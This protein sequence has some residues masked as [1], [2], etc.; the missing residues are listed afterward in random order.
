MATYGER[1]LPEELRAH[2]LEQE[3][4]TDDTLAALVARSLDAAPSQSINVWS[5][6]AEW[7]GT[8][9]EIAEESRRLA[10]ALRAAGIDSGA[11]VAFQLPNSREAIAS[12]YGLALGGYVMVPI[13]HIYGRKEVGF[14]LR[15]SGAAAYISAASF[16]HVD[17]V[18]IVD[19]EAD[20]LPDLRVHLVAGG[21]TL[22]APPPGITRLGW[23]AVDDAGGGDPTGPAV[24][25]DNPVVIGYTSGTTS[26]PKGVVHT[27]RTLLAELLHMST[28]MTPGQS[29][30]MGSPVTHA[31][32]MLG[33]VLAPVQAG[34]P[35]NIIDRWDPTRV[36][37]IVL[38]AGVSA[39]VGASF[40]LTSLMEHPNFTPEHA[41]RMG[42]VGLGGAPVPPSVGE[43]AAS[44]GITII[45]AYGSTEHPS[46][47]GGDWND[48]AEKRHSTDGRARTGVEI[49]I[50]DEDGIDL[51]TG[52]AGEIISRGP[53][54]C[55]GYTDP[56][57]TAAT[58]TDDG[59]FHTG[60]MGMLDDD[61][62]LTITDRLKDIII[63]GGENISAAEVEEIVA[64]APGVVEVAVIAAPDERL[65]ER[66]CAL[67][68]MAAGAEDL[69]LDGL[70]NHLEHAGFARQKWPEDL[71][72][73]ADFPRTATGKIRKIDLRH[74]LK[75]QT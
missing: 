11:T 47:T 6:D 49:R 56:A 63:R 70:R 44:H 1:P 67:V 39:G 60:D 65:G 20:A 13:V 7:H 8:Y 31:T 29:S 21:R 55:A 27:H 32:G 73:V 22:A 23:S 33:A 9:A 57:L 66:A 5:D 69:T 28:M 18:G 25:P 35:I 74:Q 10:N 48:S 43:T 12:F 61:G 38:E 2:Y 59:W 37:E 62:Y 36:L 51:A 68:R 72:I 14:I 54:L 75:D 16:G 64:A 15:E 19:D 52:T 26:A 45:R 34:L 17:Y 30:L 40:F 71:R 42:R 3:W 24:D 53:D 4:W 50:V 41:V 58:F 46:I